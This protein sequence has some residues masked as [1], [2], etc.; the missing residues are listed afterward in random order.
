[1][2]TADENPFASPHAAHAPRRN[3]PQHIE[4]ASPLDVRG[5]CYACGAAGEHDFEQTFYWN[6]LLVR[7]SLCR[8]CLWRRPWQAASLIVNGL[9]TLLSIVIVGYALTLLAYHPMI[10]DV[11]S[12]HTA[13][14][15]AILG[16]VGISVT[17]ILLL[18]NVVLRLFA[19]FHWYPTWLGGGL[20]RLTSL[21]ANFAANYFSR[22]EEQE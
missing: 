4:G 20:F 3:N 17:G 10:V 16:V 18:A 5:L 21:N 1:M 15:F 8:Q 19:V 6:R 9:L 12:A 7:Y 13:K 14:G 2:P 11:W 22:Q